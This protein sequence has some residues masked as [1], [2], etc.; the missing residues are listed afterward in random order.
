MPKLKKD[1]SSTT[2]VTVGELIDKLSE[3]P[4]DMPVAYFWD[5]VMVD[6]V[7]LDGIKVKHESENLITPVLL[8]SVNC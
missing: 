4:Q 2:T 3:F 6:P 8:L 7:D 5:Y 1:E